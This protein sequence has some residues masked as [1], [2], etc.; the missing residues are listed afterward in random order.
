MFKRFRHPMPAPSAPGAYRL[1]AWLLAWLVVSM[2]ALAAASAVA[3]PDDAVQRG[4]AWLASQVGSDG[5]LS[6]PADASDVQLQAASEVLLTQA[7]IGVALSQG[8]AASLARAQPAQAELIA[9]VI[10]GGTASGATSDEARASLARLAAVPGGVSPLLPYG[11]TLVDSA[12]ALRAAALAPAARSAALAFV[13]SAQRPSGAFALSGT[14]DLGLTALVLMGLTQAAPAHAEAGPAAQRAAAWLQAQQSADG[15]W[16]GSIYLTASVFEAL[17]PYIDLSTVG[18]RAR[19]A[20][21]SSQQADGSW[22]ADAALTAVALRALFLTTQAPSDP[23]RAILTARLIDAYTR[24]P[25]AG[26][27]ATL[28]AMSGGAPGASP[29]ASP[30]GTVSGADG[31]VSFRQVV[32]Q[33]VSLA[34]SRS[35]YNSVT[36]EVTLQKGA[37]TDLG[38]VL[39][40]RSAQAEASSS[41][42]SGIV[43]SAANGAVLAGATV[44]IPSLGRAAATDAAGQYLLDNLEPGSWSVVSGKPGFATQT[45]TLQTDAGRIANYSPALLPIGPSA[46]GC[47]IAGRV[48]D[49]TTGAPLAGATVSLSNANVATAVTGAD[50]RY[51]ITGLVSGVV[52]FLTRKATYRDSGASS[53]LFCGPGTVLDYSPALFPAQ[54][55]VLNGEGGSTITFV[56][57]DAGSNQPVPGAAV[58][59]TQPGLYR[60]F[61]YADAAGRIVIPDIYT[62]W[63]QL[64]VSAPDYVSVSIGHYPLPTTVNDLGQ[65]RLR[66][67]RDEQLR[68]NL[69]AVSVVRSGLSTDPQSLRMRGTV[70]VVIAN[71]GAVAVTGTPTVLAFHDADLNGRYDAGIDTVLGRI[72][73]PGS[74]AAGATATLVLAVEGPLP[75]RDAPVS[76]VVDPDERI[77]DADRSNNVRSTAQ[78]ARLVSAVLPINPRLKFHWAGRVMM[79][80]VVARIHDTN[81]DGRIDSQDVPRIIFASYGEVGGGYFGPATLYAIDG[82]TGAT[83]LRVPPSVFGGVHSQTGIA[84]GD[85]DGDGI[86][87]IVAARVGGGVVA[88]SNTGEVK[89]LTNAEP[90]PNPSIADLD[91]DGNPEVLAGGTVLD[92]R[93]GQQISRLAAC[94][95]NSYAL[96]LSP[97]D[98][99][100]VMVCGDTIGR[101]DGSV[102]WST[103]YQTF[104]PMVPGNFND[105]P[106]TEFVRVQSSN[107][108]LLSQSGGLIWGPVFLGTPGLGGAPLVADLDGDGYPEI[109]ISSGGSFT[110]LRRDGSVLWSRPTYDGSAET[111]ATAFDFG[112]NG[113]MTV[114]YRDERTLWFFDGP[115]GD[116]VYQTDSF[117]LTGSE[118]PVIADT[119]GDGK[120]RIVVPA[121]VGSLSGIAVYEDDGAGWARTRA[122]WNQFY[123]SV[124]NI[125]DDLSVP[126]LPAVS[127]RS[128]N[129]FM[130]NRLPVDVRAA[131]VDLTAAYVRVVDAGAS[132][133]SSVTFRI[134]NAGGREAPSATPVAVY[135]TSA[136]G[137]TTLAGRVTLGADLGSGRW[138]D[139][140]VPV[141]SLSGV[142]TLTI[143]AD[144]DGAGH[145][146]LNDFDSGNNQ[147][148]VDVRSIA[149]LLG[150]AAAADKPVYQAGDTAIFTSVVSN[151]GSFAQAT[152]VR[153]TVVGD[154]GRVIQ[155]LPRVGPLTVLP[156]GNAQ[157]Q[158]PWSVAGVP[159]GSYQVLVELLSSSGVVTG[160]ASVSFTVSASAAV[161]AGARLD[162]D[163]ATY[164]TTDLVTLSSVL[165][166]LTSNA[167]LQDLQAT[168][169]LRNGAGATVWQRSAALAQLTPGEVRSLPYTVPAS[170]LGAGRY[171]ATLSLAQGGAAVLATATSGFEVL[172]AS[173][174]GVGLRGTV[175]AATATPLVGQSVTLSLTA[176][177]AGDSVVSGTLTLRIV[178]PAS[179]SSLGVYSQ[180]ASIAPGASRSLSWPW[181]A[182]GADGQTLV[183]TG[184]M[185]LANRSVP[186]GQVPLVLRAAPLI[187]ASPSQLDFGTVDV[188]SASAAQTVLVRNGGGAAALTPS[189]TLGGSSSLQFS[190]SAGGCAAQGA[191]AAGAT[192]TVT[193]S[194][195]PGAA[196][197][198]TAQLVIGYAGTSPAVVALT[199][200]ARPVQLRG[201]IS[202]APGST[203]LG[204]PV[205][206]VHSLTN[207]SAVTVQALASLT[208]VDASQRTV[209]SWTLQ[210]S[211]A[212]GAS[213]AGSQPWTASA[214][215]T[216]R[217]LLS[218]TLGDA[219]VPLGSAVF[220]VQPAVT[221]TTATQPVTVAT[222]RKREARMLVLV[223]CTSQ[224]ALS[225]A[226]DDDDAQR[227]AKA[228]KCSPQ[229]D[230]QGCV[231][232][233]AGAIDA[234]LDGL[235]IIHQVVTTESAFKH[236]MRCG[237]FNSYWISGPAA[238]LDHWLVKEV[239]EAT[240]RGDGLVIDGDQD[241]R[242]LLLHPAAGV[243]YRGAQSGADL[244]VTVPS[245]SLFAPGQIAT[246]GRAIKY[247][248]A[249]GKSQARFASGLPA[250]VSNTY[251]AGNTLLFGFDLA[252]LVSGATS[253]A[254][255][256]LRD[257]VTVVATQT[258]GGTQT[259]TVGD[260]TALSVSIANPG[261]RTAVVD[262]RGTL[263][264]GLAH[265]GSSLSPVATPLPGSGATT[266]SWIVQVPARG[267][268]ELVWRVQ[269]LQA[270]AGWP[271]G[272][273]VYS[274][275]SSGTGTASLQH[276]SSFVLP[277]A[278]GSA[279]LAD[280]LP[281]TQALAP[282]TSAGKSARSAAISAINSALTLHGQGKYPDAIVQWMSA[283]NSVIAITGADTRAAH[284]AVARAAEA[285]TDVLCQ[286]LACLGGNLTLGPAQVP[287]GG[288]LA[289]TRTVSNICTAP[290]RDVAITATV[291]NR[292]SGQSLLSLTDAQSLA[293]GQASSRGANL[294]LALPA[295]QLGDWIDGVLQVTWFGHT[296][297]LARAQVQVTSPVNACVAGEPLAPSRFTAFGAN[298]GLQARG[299]KSGSADWE[300]AVGRDTQTKGYAGT[301][302]L[303]WTS[304]K[305]YYW[306][307]AV[308]SAGK[309]SLSVRDGGKVVAEA[310][311]SPG[312]NSAYRM[313][314]GNALSLAV[315]TAGDAGSARVS[316]SFT[317]VGGKPVDATVATDAAGQT[318]SV[319]IYQPALGSGLTA[320]GTVTLN[321]SGS[322]PP[323][324]ARLLMN[325]Q[326][327]TASCQ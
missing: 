314:L 7:R 81:G 259:L 250:I 60:Y 67:V 136:A 299:G 182:S 146:T 40:I 322:T 35:G 26:V 256:W 149:T 307:Y 94:S 80:P 15:S 277:V 246:Q 305:T 101:R 43:R 133:V 223:S 99:Q 303:T 57:L 222:Q 325:L 202:V 291:S 316:A 12:W 272:L 236:A 289:M 129:T 269:A 320:E 197:T 3:Q 192:C 84:I 88:L 45:T 122:L 32:P 77:P 42:I 276:T 212:A 263:P 24:T 62:A 301:G 106:D 120:A 195:R 75:F 208:V 190:L 209:A 96:R 225:H 313:R 27:T 297:E 210:P 216:Y 242:S 63:V 48:T 177:N 115:T 321:F 268:V 73:G 179:G 61:A 145:T 98:A 121:D 287:V 232:D 47:S 274:L 119:Q 58:T 46:Q 224:Q 229:P 53:R 21:L 85:I 103:N 245:G 56:V 226:E 34:L 213:F 137:L 89:W 70:T 317:R 205:S 148:A 22:D 150:I 11:P 162:T 201:S 240:W 290:A 275:P 23:T 69:S 154:G 193:V 306:S 140:T 110:V 188:A 90:T 117:S 123:Y 284:D 76:V 254:P 233:R 184:S 251:G 323:A 312:G 17:H 293:A 128:H 278:A 19:A 126:R 319:V 298:E 54:S 114:V 241:D 97:Q 175:T 78:A 28:N 187:L 139:L 79:P 49:G 141:A 8:L 124:D 260:I 302:D 153:L 39:L 295:S 38:D 142:A 220:S 50:G 167:L 176:L 281:R 105:D 207:P 100:Q 234:L 257:M 29:G 185:Q 292:R 159:A 83:V 196:G 324:G 219:S 327:G 244:P 318:R 300:W 248:L 200:T 191:L 158:T 266:L 165:S 113:R 230:I 151:G 171:T 82:E 2:L 255:A 218:Q 1:A 161:A 270:S 311:Y 164:A 285:T 25:L 172:N 170:D 86:P 296:L 294:R 72:D 13:L 183:V 261:T 310:S 217:A 265:A 104:Q 152:E 33:A 6:L 304:G 143:V 198:H 9:R 288:N 65:V 147:V 282:T 37:T 112:G 264:A 253:P 109:G 228:E 5:R 206:L 127:T 144:D 258:A 87:E 108:S 178:D 174:T 51:V 309:G 279:L 160:S 64:D 231:D 237:A 273:A 194:Y 214:T 66:R 169:V 111:G 131:A 271:V 107:V 41:A 235:G 155:V 30:N 249:G 116:V 102:V 71:S 239:R 267:S 59:Y 118:Y 252:E 132:G 52:D 36:V 20:L 247:D 14:D 286:T 157:A 4:A 211:L 10:A 16:G 93:T 134:G 156:G 215:G 135:R 203:T 168:T 204:Q 326:A 138:V 280:A 44:A 199:G 95:P 238:K 125:N 74:L 227:S 92:G 243:V 163:R 18:A 221:A 166:N 308:D 91:G 173:A 55:P 181:T 180:A 283:A 315:S 31:V 186:L 68:Q 262:I 189:M 130:L